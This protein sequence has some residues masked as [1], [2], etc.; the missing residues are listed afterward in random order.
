[1]FVLLGESNGLG[2]VVGFA[3]NNDDSL[4]SGFFGGEDFRVRIGVVLEVMDVAVGVDKHELEV[5][6][7]R[8]KCG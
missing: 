3:P 7:Q 1:M 6:S 8:L 4:D 5:G 2:P